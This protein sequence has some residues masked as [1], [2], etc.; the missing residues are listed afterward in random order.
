MG[1]F[2]LP[3]PPLSFKVLYTAFHRNTCKTQSSLDCSYF[4]LNLT[5]GHKKRRCSSE[6]EE[7][8]GGPFICLT[9]TTFLATYFHL[10][11]H[12]EV[13][14]LTPAFPEH[15][16]I[17]LLNLSC[18]IP[19]TGLHVTLTHVTTIWNPAIITLCSSVMV[20]YVFLTRNRFD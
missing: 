20:M 9:G 16:N 1:F 3:V 12:V 19:T 11:I 5:S 2:Q 4:W 8:G 14:I 15:N 6:V 7:G 18:G 10:N 17:V 13:L